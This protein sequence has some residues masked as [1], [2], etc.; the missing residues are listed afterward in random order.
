MTSPAPFPSLPPSCSP[1]D[2]HPSTL[3]LQP[4]LASSSSSFRNLY[5]FV[6]SPFRSRAAPAPSESDEDEDEAGDES[7]PIELGDS[8]EDMEEQP[9]TQA[10]SSW[11]KGNG[12]EAQRNSAGGVS[13]T[14][15]L[16]PSF[17]LVPSCLPVAQS[18]LPHALYSSPAHPALSISRPS[19][20]SPTPT[21]RNGPRPPSP[22]RLTLTPWSRWSPLQRSSQS[23]ATRNP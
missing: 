23:L 10:A 8:D 7:Q 3:P 12:R 13:P 15:P 21:R 6:S 18:R 2:L 20:P 19:L 1:S 9:A 4:T 5:N 16:L 17:E 11:W 22:L 14:F